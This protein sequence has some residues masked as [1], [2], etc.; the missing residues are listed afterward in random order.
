MI[1]EY[2]LSAGDKIILVIIGRWQ[3]TNG[4]LREG[5]DEL[6][7]QLCA[8]GVLL[9]VVDDVPYPG[10]RKADFLGFVSTVTSALASLLC[11]SVDISSQ[12]AAASADSWTLEFEDMSAA[13]SSAGGTAKP[14]EACTCTRHVVR[15]VALHPWA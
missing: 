2:N 15:R 7:K 12:Q 13:I 6:I 11:P 14:V 10:Q 5:R 8:R 4:P 1:S 9:E 3:G